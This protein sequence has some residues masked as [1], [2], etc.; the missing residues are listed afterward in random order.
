MHATSAMTDLQ[1]QI[2]DRVL[3]NLAES[4][5]WDPTRIEQLRA[6]LSAKKRVK[7]DDLVS[8]FCAITSERAE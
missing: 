6:V 7:P 3:K 2:A 1:Q 5:N 8:V 4:Q